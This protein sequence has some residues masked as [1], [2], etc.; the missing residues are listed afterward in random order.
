M[1]SSRVIPTMDGMLRTI[2]AFS[3]LDHNGYWTEIP[4]HVVVSSGAQLAHTQLTADS[5]KSLTLRGVLDAATDIAEAGDPMGIAVPR[6]P[7]DLSSGPGLI[8]NEN[9]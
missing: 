3:S 2:R 9:E 1:L 8:D 5:V 7:R 6:E 4:T